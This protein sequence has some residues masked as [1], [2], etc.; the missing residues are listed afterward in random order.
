MDNK[1]NSLNWFEIPAQDIDRAKKFYESVFNITMMRTEMDKMQM[2][3]FSFEAFEGGSGK[4][5]GAI[6]QS[7][8]HVPS[9]EGAI[10]YLNANPKLA[11][12]LG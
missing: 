5:T 7:N 1:S 4:A 10:I 12:A 11:L 8:M 3:F 6:V 9:K 2:A